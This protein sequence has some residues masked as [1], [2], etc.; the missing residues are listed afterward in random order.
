MDYTKPIFMKNL[1]VP[2][3]CSLMIVASGSSCN[4][5]HKSLTTNSGFNLQETLNFSAAHRNNMLAFDLLNEMDAW[6]KNLVFSP[7]SISTA[8]AMAYVGANASTRE[9]M[10]TVLYFNLNK[11]RFLN[12]F[13]YLQHKI[14]LS[15]GDTLL[16]M[17]NSIWMQQHHNF[18]QGYLNNI[19]N[20]FGAKPK[21]VDFLQG[22]LM[23]IKNQINASVSEQTGGKIEDLIQPGILTPDTRLMLVNA[24]HFNARWANTFDSNKT[25]KMDFR[26]IDGSK[27]GTM[28]MQQSAIFH[29]LERDD[30]QVLKMPYSGDTFSMIIILPSEQTTLANVEQKMTAK[31][32]DELNESLSYQRVQLLFP[33]FRTESLANLNQILVQLGME[34]AFAANADFSGMTG[35]KELKIDHVLHQSNIEVAEEGTEAAAATAVAITQKSLI[36]HEEPEIV[37]HANR[38]FLYAIVENSTNT[39]L[40]LGRKLQF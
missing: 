38:P 22:D 4:R 3:L 15:S 1:I 18:R 16:R 11:R 8:L 35:K 19:R 34:K 37:F 31:I 10:A 14:A 36:I 21:T 30:F 32:F 39:I 2:V 33:R 26:N 40:F 6:E 7:F 28:F 20:H 9:E 13:D 17:A 27:T 25:Q 24:L 29:Y 5:R 23:Q 12:D